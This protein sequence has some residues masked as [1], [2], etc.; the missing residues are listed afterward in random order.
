MVPYHKFLIIATALSEVNMNYIAGSSP[1]CHTYNI[2][3]ITPEPL[4]II[5][6]SFHKN[7]KNIGDDIQIQKQISAASYTVKL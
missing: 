1:F 5:I 3:C 7:S 4:Q 2:N 6:K